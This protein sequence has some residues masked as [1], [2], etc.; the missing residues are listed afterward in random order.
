MI[1]PN[2]SF[3]FRG[4]PRFCRTATL[5]L[6]MAGAS[7]AF[8]F[9]VDTSPIPSTHHSAAPEEGLPVTIN[10]P[11]MVWREDKTADSYIIEFSQD[12]NFP[13]GE[14]LIRVQ[15]ITLPFYNHNAP[16]EQGTWF[17]RYFVVRKDGSVSSPAPVKSFVVTEQA[18]VFPIPSMKEIYAIMPEHPR[19]FVTPKTLAQFQQKRQGEGK[20]AWETLQLKADQALRG[21]TQ[22]TGERIPLAKAKIEHSTDSLSHSWK[23]GDPIRRQVFLLDENE[24]LF[25][26]PQNTIR[27]LGSAASRLDTL[28]LAW[29]ISGDERYLDGARKLIALVAPLRLDAHLSDNERSEHDTVV[30]AYEQGLKAVAL[31]YD[32][33]YHE[34]NEQERAAMLAHIEFH[35][36][37]A[38]NWLKKVDLHNRYQQSH[39]QQCMHALLVTVLAAAKDS[40]QIDKWVEYIVPQYMNR[41]AWTSEDGGYFEG[42]TY[43]HKFAWILEGL[44]AIRSATGVDLFKKPEI[45]NSGEYWLY[46]MNMNYWFHHWGDVYSLIWPHANG[47]DAFITAFLAAM[48]NDPYVKWYSQSVLTNPEVSPF[49]YLS[50]G[51]LKARPP[52]DIPQARL[53]PLTGV[54]TAYNGLYDHSSERIFFRSSRWGSHSHSHADQNAFVIHSGG[55]ILAPDTGYYTYSGDIY[56][57]QWSKTTFAHNS[58]LVNGQPQPLGIASKGEI[59]SFFQ[60]SRLTYFVGDASEAYAKPLKDFRRAILYVRPATYIVY[61]ELAAAEAS[62]YSWLLNV[63]QKPQIDEKQNRILVEQQHMRMQVDTLLPKRVKYSANNDRLYPIKEKRRMWSRFTEAFPQPWHIRVENATRTKDESFLT[64]MQTW[65]VADGSREQAGT[66]IDTSSTVGLSYSSKDESAVVLF[67]RKLNGS[68]AISGESLHAKAQAAALFRSTKG[69]PTNWLVAAG[70]ELEWNRTP[71]FRSEVVVSASARFDTPAAA[72]LLN[73]EGGSPSVALWLAAEP[74]ALFIAP[75]SKP[76]EARP[77]AFSWDAARSAVVFA[78]EEGNPVAVWVDPVVDLT[79]PLKK[80]ELEVTD[81]E[82]SYKVALEPAWTEGGEVMYFAEISPREIGS[83]ALAAQ[84]QG[85]DSASLLIQDRWDPYSLSSRGKGSVN[86]EIRNGSWLYLSTTPGSSGHFSAKLTERIGKGVIDNVLFNGDFEFGIP[87]Y[88]PRGWTMSFRRSESMTWSHWTQED[89]KSGKSSMRHVRYGSDYELVSRPMRL[90][91]GGE[92]HLRF[93]ARGDIGNARLVVRGARSTGATV[94][95]KPSGEWRLYEASFTLAPGYTTVAIVTPDGKKEQELWVDGI[96]L[97]QIPN[98]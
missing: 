53:F 72:A 30:Y 63:F 78:V 4:L 70:T 26:L 98:P 54:V 51:P 17:W 6:C 97:G 89:A 49:D 90:L 1:I 71:L 50:A 76:Q 27:L 56:H 14:S 16:L 87:N 75:A 19:I 73:V 18:E 45:R 25:W 42:Q 80:G 9:N 32:R 3:L 23:K 40:P 84:G 11:S 66:T 52:V 46:A 61:D 55:E 48:N 12:K 5:S 10:P 36:D 33:L 64:L 81:S 82:G 21:T 95:I 35:A 8:A 34:L 13:K 69:E 22:I 74:K 2:T 91:E 65:D 86:G 44:A 39:P 92:Y 28:S 47:R 96:E 83:Y 7:A 31:A 60:G 77:L 38:G 58:M 79:A 59:D 57:Q 62:T 37:A 88:P 94:A 67:R 20:E 43:G 85:S 15:G 29:Q 93:Y 41:I 68:E 24:A